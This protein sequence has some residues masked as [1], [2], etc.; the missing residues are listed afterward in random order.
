MGDYFIG[1]SQE[2]S[3]VDTKPAL[4]SFSDVFRAEIDLPVISG[5]DVRPDNKTAKTEYCPAGLYSSKHACGHIEGFP[6]KMIK[7]LG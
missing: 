2:L 6:G 4:F 1:W 7:S 3:P 5:G